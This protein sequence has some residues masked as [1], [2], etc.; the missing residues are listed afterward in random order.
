M[1]FKLYRK[2]KS[3]VKS[4]FSLNPFI[5]LNSSSKCESSQFSFSSLPRNS[6]QVVSQSVRL[7]ESVLPSLKRLTDMGRRDS[8]T[9]HLDTCQSQPTLP[10]NCPDCVAALRGLSLYISRAASLEFSPTHTI[11][12]RN[13]L[14]IRIF[15]PKKELGRG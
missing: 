13:R 12:P 3:R 4:C 10:G 7:S 8:P 2:S 14:Q 15:D 11:N 9:C 6:R 5:Y 1:R